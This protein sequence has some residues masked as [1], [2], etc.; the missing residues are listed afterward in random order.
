MEH[1]HG[2]A[3]EAVE[4]VYR[5]V[6]NTHVFS[7]RGIRGLVHTGS[8]DRK[9][10]FDR[11]MKCLNGHVKHVYGDDVR[12]HADMSYDEFAGH[13]DNDTNISANFLTLHLDVPLAA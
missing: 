13:L 1:N 8:H 4:L 10:A 6:G 9:T 7:S 5:V 11:V 2:G 3:P 12:Y